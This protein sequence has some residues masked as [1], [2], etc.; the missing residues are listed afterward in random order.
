MGTLTALKFLTPEGAHQMASLLPDLQKQELI[1]VVDA[2]IVSWPVGTS[3]RKIRRLHNLAGPGA[4]DGG[5][6]VTLFGLIFYVPLLGM[7]IVTL[8]SPFTEAGIDEEFLQRT[9]DKITEGTSALFLMTDKV[10]LEQVSK[11]VESKGIHF[12]LV[13]TAYPKSQRR[14]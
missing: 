7:N 9:R 12:E 3:T 13:T 8:L 1:M 14:N 2:A 5:F 11:A 4:Q 6:W 10:A